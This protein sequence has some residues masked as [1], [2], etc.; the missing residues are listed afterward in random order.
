M[1]PFL[2]DEESPRL[3]SV[4][5]CT[6]GQI[7]KVFCAVRVMSEVSGHC[8]VC[9]E[10]LHWI[11]LFG[12]LSVL[13]EN[14]GYSLLLKDF[15]YQVTLISS[16]FSKNYQQPHGFPFSF[17]ITIAETL[18]NSNIR[19]LAAKST[20]IGVIQKWFGSGRVR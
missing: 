2:A 4:P 6:F 5:C 1:Q 12:H 9:P 19:A 8:T 3:M 18:L 14:F 16:F 10:T 15:Y 17:G 20:H 11:E 13:S 7:S